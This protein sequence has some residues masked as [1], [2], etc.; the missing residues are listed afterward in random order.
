VSRFKVLFFLTGREGG[1]YAQRLWFGVPRVGDEVMLHSQ[2][3]GALHPH[4][5]VRVVWGNEDEGFF[6]HDHQ[7]QQVNVEVQE[8]A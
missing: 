1:A 8:I 3:D 4:Q 7:V 2:T 5:V 6:A